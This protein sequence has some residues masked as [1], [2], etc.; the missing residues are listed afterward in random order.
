MKSVPSVVQKVVAYARLLRLSNAPT[1]MADVWMGYALSTGAFS[2]SVSLVLLT[3]TSLCLYHG[4]MALNDAVDAKQDQ[5]DQRGRPIEQQLVSR[6]RAYCTAY[7]LFALGLVFAV[8]SSYYTDHP[9][10]LAAIVL[11]VLVISY[12][13]KLKRTAVGP[14]IMAAC[15]VANVELGLS[16]CVGC[17]EL[18]TAEEIG[19][20]RL[21]YFVYIAGLTY[22]AREESA[23][24][25]ST[26]HGLACAASLFGVLAIGF[27]YSISAPPGFNA[28]QWNILWLVVAMF[29]TRGMVAAIIQPTPRN[30]GRGVGI[31]IQGIIVIDATLATLYAGPMAGLA[32]FTLLP[33][34]MLLSRWI[35]QT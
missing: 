21:G 7:G 14:L 22:F 2:P 3:L 35:P 30:I 4:G 12:N 20:Y 28:F 25:S 6:R 33:V 17:S 16:Q 10:V 19:Y 9:A 31:A 8:W 34:T 23:D 27:L 26:N 32:I 13:S 18:L 1:A 15:R 5:A 29:C 11:I 24:E